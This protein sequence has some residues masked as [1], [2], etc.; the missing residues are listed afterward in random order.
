[1]FNTPLA[2]ANGWSFDWRSALIGAGAA[3]LIALILY[4]RRASVDARLRQ[5]WNPLARWQEQLRSS[6]AEKYLA[7]LQQA[8]R[9]TLLFEPA[10]PAAIFVPPVLLAP[11]ALPTTL[12]EDV[13]LTAQQPI[14]YEQLLGGHP[15]LLL[16]GDK[17]QGRTMA[18]ALLV[19]QVDQTNSETVSSAPYTR[20]P[21]WIDLAQLTELPENEETDPVEFLTELAVKFLP[22]ARAKWLCKQLLNA[23]AVILIDNW[24]SVPGAD[25]TTVTQLI[26]AAAQ[27][28]PESKWIVVT[29][30]EGYA[31][32]TEADF[33]PVKVQPRIDEEALHTIYNG[34]ATQLEH[35]E[36]ELGEPFLPTLQ[37]AL[38]SGDTLLDF[39]LRTI[40]YL[41]TGLHPER[42]ITVQQ[43]LLEELLPTQELG[44]EE[45]EI[46]QEAKRIALETLGTLAWQLKSG[47]QAHFSPTEVESLVETLFPPPTER[48]SQLEQATYKLLRERGLLRWD[49]ELVTFKH[50]IWEDFFTASRCSQQTE[51]PPALLEHL[52]DPAWIFTKEYYLGLGEAQALVKAQLQASLASDD[53]RALLTAARWAMLAPPEAQWRKVVMKVLA[54][55]FTKSNITLADRM[56]L[57]RALTLVAGESIRPFFLQTLRRHRAPD[58][59]AAALRGLGWTGTPKE[60][61]ILAGGLTAPD[62]ATR[63]SAVRALGDLGTPGAL[64]LLQEQLPLVDEKLML[65]LAEALAA[66]QDGG[67]EI[68][69]RAAQSKDLLARRAAIHGLGKIQ[70]P[71]TKE[72]LEYVQRED[73]QWL[74]RSAA[75]AALSEMEKCSTISSATVQPPPKMDELPWL[76]NW[77]AEQGLGVGVGKAAMQILLRVLESDNPEAQILA[78]AS[79]AQIGRREHLA[80]LQELLASPEEKVQAAAN[81]AINQIEKRYAGLPTAGE[82]DCE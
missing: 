29:G 21:L 77:A 7:A 78:A 6:V 16:T 26:T 3:W 62:F 38:E 73:P 57:G 70:E 17:G 4:L 36:K 30:Q 55:T 56:R 60:M 76:I 51:M 54:Q 41:R 52:R 63:E 27:Q 8:L 61:R 53:Q 72:I 19:W 45:L 32:L 69:K 40:L 1:M 68:L 39:N 15:R 75:E 23:P 65:I 35:E 64:R 11:P 47:E 28:L 81:Y 58:I 42:P 34:W 79:L 12:V 67:G 48:T 2:L 49:K 18:L 66:N 71:W 43:A 24:G 10:D 20:F 74:V 33:V 31:P 82:A 22:A 59:R 14:A 44:E 46:A 13:K 5:L 37:R 25:R 9:A 50:Y 80:A